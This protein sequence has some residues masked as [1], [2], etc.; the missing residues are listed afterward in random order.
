MLNERLR[1]CHTYSV[2]AALSRREPQGCSVYFTR[3]SKSHPG[4]KGTFSPALTHGSIVL[5]PFPLRDPGG[6]LSRSAAR[7]RRGRGAAPGH[8]RTL[9]PPRGS[10]APGRWILRHCAG[11]PGRP[12]VDA[13]ARGSNQSARPRGLGAVARRMA[14]RRD[15]RPGR[16]GRG[17]GAV[18]P[19]GDACVDGCP[20]RHRGRPCAAPKPGG[21]VPA[22]GPEARRHRRGV[23]RRWG[24]AAPG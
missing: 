13:R 5:H 14:G 15:S 11:V 4:T 18:S 16:P 12:G 10:P 6:P 7:G 3:S 21:S 20:G 8:L 24:P 1:N 19:V 2:V 23:G 9:R 17:N 22:G